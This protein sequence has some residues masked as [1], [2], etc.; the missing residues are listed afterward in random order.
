M[1]GVHERSMTVLELVWTVVSFSMV[2]VISIL[3]IFLPMRF[4]EKGLSK[5]LP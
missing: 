5:V 3:A 1:A 4:G 2:V